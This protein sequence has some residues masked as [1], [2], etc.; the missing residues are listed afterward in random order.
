MPA[1]KRS[2]NVLFMVPRI[3]PLNPEEFVRKVNNNLCPMPD[4]N[5]VLPIRSPLPLEGYDTHIHSVDMYAHAA[6]QSK[7]TAK[8]IQ[9]S[10]NWLG[11]SIRSILYMEDK[12]LGN[13][14]SFQY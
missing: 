14:H 1:S 10:E 6:Y 7:V 9:E 8:D 5:I 13:Y 12:Y 2:P 4:W 3:R 11:Y